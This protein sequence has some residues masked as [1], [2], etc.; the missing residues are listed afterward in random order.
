MK[1]RKHKRLIIGMLVILSIFSLEKVYATE[2]DLKESE[3]SS[4][5]KEYI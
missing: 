2:N 4:E 3:Y 5:Y 1:I